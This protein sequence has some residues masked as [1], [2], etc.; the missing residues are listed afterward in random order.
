MLVPMATVTHSEVGLQFCQHVTGIVA[1]PLGLLAFA[2]ERERDRA[3]LG[4]N[5]DDEVFEGGD[6]S[7]GCGG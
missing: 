7:G 1:Q 4:G 2:L 3:V 5:E 6:A